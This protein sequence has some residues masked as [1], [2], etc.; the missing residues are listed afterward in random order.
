MRFQIKLGNL[1]VCVF[2]NFLRE[3]LL[4]FSLQRLSRV[5]IETG[6]DAGLDGVGRIKVCIRRIKIC[7]FPRCPS[8]DRMDTPN[9]I[10]D[11]EAGVDPQIEHSIR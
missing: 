6:L 3:R 5:E 7:Y 8:A 11:K 2:F 9:W 4:T 1:K 10:A